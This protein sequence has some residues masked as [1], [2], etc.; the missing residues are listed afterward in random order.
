MVVKYKIDNE[1]QGS[2]RYLRRPCEIGQMKRCVQTS[3][4]PKIVPF[5]LG[6]VLLVGIVGNLDMKQSS[7]VKC[8]VCYC[9]KRTGHGMDEVIRMPFKTKVVDEEEIAENC[10]ECGERRG[11]VF[12]DSGKSDRKSKSDHEYAQIG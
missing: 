12:K 8:F 11:R 2:K 7:C 4:C 9:V 6:F 10:R 3:R 5:P 1:K